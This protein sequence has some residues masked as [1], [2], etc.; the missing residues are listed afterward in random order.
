M[1]KPRSVATKTLRTSAQI[2]GQQKLDGFADII[3]YP[4]PFP[5]SRHDGGKIVVC[6][7]HI[8]NIFRYIRTCDTH[9]DTDIG[10]F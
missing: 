10:I 9:T 7:N 5:D 2:R 4:P 1:T 8:G 3:V 6:E